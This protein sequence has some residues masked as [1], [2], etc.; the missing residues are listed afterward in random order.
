MQHTHARW[1]IVLAAGE[2]SRLSS[3]TTDAEGRVVPKQYCSLDGRDSLLGSARRRAGRVVP[4]DRIL[5]VVARQHSRWWRAPSTSAL[6]V[7]PENRGTAA[8]VL[9]PLLTVLDRDPEALVMLLPSDHFVEREDLLA[10]A[11]E[12]AFAH[13]SLEPEAI[14]LL[15]VTPHD[16][17]ADYGWIVPRSP[18]PDV[19]PVG[20]F[21]EKPGPEVARSLRRQGALWNAF[22]VVARAEA[23]R[24]LYVRRAPWLLLA[25]QAALAA[26]QD[27]RAAALEQ[28]Y[29]T[30]GPLDF[31]RDLLEGSERWLRVL[32]VPECG[33]TDLGVPERLAACLSGRTRDLRDTRRPR[34][35]R[36]RPDLALNLD[37]TLALALESIP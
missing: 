34:R 23:L 32:A 28:I 12:R 5:T 14:V 21:V 4:N 6:V 35:R 33:W 16:A 3:L 31:S 30:L 18:G 27:R 13:T 10:T 37:R 29:A 20:R 9:L 15:G 7:Q 11:V 24:N 17:T 19:E 25:L 8:G 2:G 36:A 26:P 22:V 1:A